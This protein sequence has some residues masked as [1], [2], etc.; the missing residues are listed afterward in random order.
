MVSFNSL[1]F[2]FGI[3]NLM[4]GNAGKFP[5]IQSRKIVYLKSFHLSESR[6]MMMMM[7][8]IHL[9]SELFLLRRITPCVSLLYCYLLSCKVDNSLL[10][11]VMFF[12]LFLAVRQQLV[13]LITTTDLLNFMT[14]ML[15]SLCVHTVWL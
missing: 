4:L 15:V 11:F 7:T 12:L 9:G 8:M 13:V 10:L 14:R 1:S 6:E 2:Y 3:S 5:V